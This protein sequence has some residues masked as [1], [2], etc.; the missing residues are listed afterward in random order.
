[1]ETE[2]KEKLENKVDLIIS[3]LKNIEDRLTKLESNTTDCKISCKNM[4]AHIS[5]IETVYDNLKNKMFG[6]TYY[7]PNLYKS[8][9]IT[10]QDK[11]IE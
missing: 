6:L 7:L 2:N 9:T 4:D 11:Y 8:N 3:K 5:F 10:S 1:M